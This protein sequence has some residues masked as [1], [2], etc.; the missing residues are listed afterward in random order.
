MNYE[1][2][3]LEEKLVVGVSSKTSN[4]DPDMGVIIGGLWNELYQGGVS[5]RLIHALI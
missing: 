2:V 4:D 3:E 1:I 5:Y